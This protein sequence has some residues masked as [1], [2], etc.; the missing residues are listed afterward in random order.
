VE[1]DGTQITIHSPNMELEQLLALVDML[2]PARTDPPPL[3]REE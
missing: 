3:S 2:V 1:R